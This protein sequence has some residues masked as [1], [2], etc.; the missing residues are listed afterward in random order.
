MSEPTSDIT[1]V[2]SVPAETPAADNSSVPLGTAPVDGTQ[3]PVPLENA[4]SED[5]S[6]TPVDTADDLNKT[7]PEGQTAQPFPTE[8]SD[9]DSIEADAERAEIEALLSTPNGPFELST[10]TAVVIRQ[11]NLREFLRLLKII[12]RGAGAS[13]SSMSLDFNDPDSFV[14]TLLAMILFAV[15]EA[16]DE[17]VDFIQSMVDPANLSPNSKMALDQRVAL[18]EELSN[19]D[20]EDMINILGVIVASEGKDLQKLGKRLR[21][22]FSTASKFG[23]TGNLTTN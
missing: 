8:A 20:L 21:A 1:P 18:A 23:L 11:M 4:K 10:G 12:S 22:M 2:E 14:Q 6:T 17:T 19:P 5:A 13:L 9:A 16:E 7:V 15:P 3:A